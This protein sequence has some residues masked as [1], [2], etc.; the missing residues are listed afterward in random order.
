MTANTARDRHKMI[1]FFK[2]L[3]IRSKLIGS[4]TIIFITATLLGSAVIYYTVKSTIE[5]N[6]ERELTNS[7]AAILNMVQTATTTS[8]KNHL[9]AVA[10]KNKE[11]I[12]GIY[13]DHKNGLMTEAA[14]KELSQK[15]L[16]S[17]TIGKTGYIFCANS[18]AIAVVHPNPGVKGKNF[19]AYGF[20][21]DMIR[22]KQGYLEYDW[23][24]PEDEKNRP[25]AQYMAYFKPWDWIIA[26]SSY[27][28][29][30]KDLIEVDDFKEN[31]LSLKFGKTGYAY[32]TDSKGNLIVHPFLE[33]NYYDSK[34][35]YGNYFVKKIAELK[36]GKLV[37]FWKNPQEI[38]EREKLVIFNY[39][40]EY[41]WII[42]SASYLDEI[43]LPL[44]II[45]QI[46]LT[47]VF[48][49]IALVCLTSFWVNNT[50]IE[51][52]KFLMNR[53]SI[54]A[55]GNLA[56]RMPVKS[57]DEI[58]QL[59][60]YFNDFME[61]LEKYSTSLESEIKKHRET[62]KALRIS[63][64]MFS[65]AFRSSPSGMLIVA[66]EN[67]EILNA[68]DSFLKIS[69]Y[70]P[71]Q[72]IGTTLKKSNF[73]FNAREGREVLKEINHKNRLKSMEFQFLNSNGDKRTGVTSAE[74]VDVGGEKC[75]LIAMEDITESRQL[76]REVL[77]ISEKERQ[78]IAMELHD[79]LCPQLIGI[80]VLTKLLSL[81]LEKKGIAESRN[82]KKI[83]ALILES[84]DKT[85]QL[86]R[87]L[88][89]VNLSEHGLDTALKELA[90][91]ISDVFRIPCRL[92]C[93]FSKPFKE[94]SVAV[95]LYYIAHEA[96]HNA[97]KHAEAKKIDI[98]LTENNEKITLSIKDNGKGL[99]NKVQPIG[100]GMKIMQYR[101]A[102]IGASFNIIDVA[103][104]GT[105]VLI[106]I[107]KELYF[108]T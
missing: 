40:P 13:I 62:E 106:K 47:I 66:M 43:Y 81:R 67:T 25:K 16:L 94:S 60:D 3:Q 37:Y 1:T 91:Y 70:N 21:R 5:T 49:I 42:A 107:D 46:I 4:F 23:K 50:V 75:M 52:L 10:E 22:L 89:P 17:Q 73:F 69:G 19:M 38:V 84:I 20:V 97:V 63:E 80:E 28:E 92:T 58:G 85:R 51:P 96:V 15:I 56:I 86:S 68:N 18:K 11:I 35:Q 108:S 72:L 78:K 36:S 79:D 76:E 59:A 41:D 99:N 53:L 82:A 98:I 9:R 61:K 8:I 101:A 65:K 31:I 103:G 105:I 55:S 57:R 29:E 48:F 26:V 102:M 6:I 87:G 90:A 100:M 104:G 14:A 95:H 44:K 54:G 74:V 64:E 34:D 83:R 88:F 33:G 32:I 30:F 45:R 2:N 77:H 12:Q 24:N 71:S 39:I 7:T 27:R 93:S